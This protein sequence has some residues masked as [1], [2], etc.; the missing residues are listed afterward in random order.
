M[1]GHNK[2]IL[3]WTHIYDSYKK[4]IEYTWNIGIKD[5]RNSKTTMYY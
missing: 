4:Y 1:T 2:Q 3:I 5:Y